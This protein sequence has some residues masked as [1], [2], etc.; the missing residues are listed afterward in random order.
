MFEFDPSDLNLIILIIF[1]QHK[2]RLV[3]THRITPGVH[4]FHPII[5]VTIPPG[6]MH[7]WGIS[8]H[9]VIHNGHSGHPIL[10]VSFRS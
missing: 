8:S 4:P 10:R 1:L 7:I 5:Y 3:L 2:I 6:I 9:H